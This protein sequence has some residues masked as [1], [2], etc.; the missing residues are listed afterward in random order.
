MFIQVPRKN[1]TDPPHSHKAKLK[2]LPAHVVRWCTDGSGMAG[3]LCILAVASWALYLKTWSPWRSGLE[4]T[5]E[6][7]PQVTGP[8]THA[9][10]TMCEQQ[11]TLQQTSELLSAEKCD[12]QQ[13]GKGHHHPYISTALKTYSLYFLKNFPWGKEMNTFSDKENNNNSHNNDKSKI[14]TC[15]CIFFF[16][17]IYFCLMN[18]TP[19][20]ERGECWETRREMSTQGRGCCFPH[21]WGWCWGWF[22]CLICCW[23]FSFCSLL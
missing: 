11:W 9:T 2:H 21:G 18:L 16:L 7:T 6:G 12:S 19:V 10:C 8:G 14:S 5:W 4:S 22:V 23:K 15:K 20:R 17:E 13:V 3:E 1:Q